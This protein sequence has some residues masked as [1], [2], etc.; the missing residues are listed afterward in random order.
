MPRKESE[1]VPESNAPVLQQEKIV[2]GEPTLADAYRRFEERFDK[3]QKRMH[4]FFDGMASC[5]NRWNK[6]L[7]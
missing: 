3:Q 7:D 2:S 5:F 1:A 6:K 4:S